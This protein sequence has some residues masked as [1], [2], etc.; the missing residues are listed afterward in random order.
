M[1][2]ESLV[3]SRFLHKPIGEFVYQEIQVTSGIFHVII[4][5]GT[6]EC[7]N[8]IGWNR[9][10]PRS[11]FFHLDRFQFVLKKWQ[12]KIQKCSPF[13]FIFFSITY[14]SAKK[15]G[16]KQNACK[17]G[18]YNWPRSWCVRSV[19]TISV[20]ILP[21]RPPARFNKYTTRQRAW[22]NSACMAGTN[23]FLR[24]ILSHEIHS[25]FIY[26]TIFIKSAIK[27]VIY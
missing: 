15:P 25:K 21:Y 24:K 18:E 9:Y 22:H 3:F 7:T 27:F 10:W 23:N 16:D 5:L 20:K 19:L 1:S 11:G 14:G 2:H 26:G 12:T 13:S 4:W 8:L 17:M 6:I